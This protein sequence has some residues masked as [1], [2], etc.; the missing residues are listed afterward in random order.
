MPPPKTYDF[1]SADVE[2][3]PWRSKTFFDFR[4]NGKLIPSFRE[5]NK[6]YAS[7]SRRI[8]DGIITRLKSEDAYLDVE[9]GFGSWEIFAE[10]YVSQ[11]FYGIQWYVLDKDILADGGVRRYS[12]QTC[13]L[14]PRSLNVEFRTAKVGGFCFCEDHAKFIVRVGYTENNQQKKQFLGYFDTPEEA[15]AVY[16]QA[17]G[18]KI[19]NVLSEKYKDQIEEHVYQAL[20]NWKIG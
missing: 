15:Q 6:C 10:W 7:L 2:L 17:V 20:K 13:C 8:Y 18:D 11:K 4:H 12:A 9:D 14:I 16:F 3:V 1:T 19:R 5:N